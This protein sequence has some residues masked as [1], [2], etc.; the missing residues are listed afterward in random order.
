MAKGQNNCRQG[1]KFR[2]SKWKEQ[3]LGGLSARRLKRK[4]LLLSVVPVP[5]CYVPILGMIV[6]CFHISANN[7]CFD[8]NGTRNPQKS[9]DTPFTN[10]AE[11]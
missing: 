9:L 10:R 4:R 6:P 3:F 1:S 8:Y 7:S 11:I 5:D 2:S